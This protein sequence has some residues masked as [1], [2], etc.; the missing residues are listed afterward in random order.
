MG[1][2]SA[3]EHLQTR[4]QKAEKVEIYAEQSHSYQ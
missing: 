4:V 2:C 3:R 1:R